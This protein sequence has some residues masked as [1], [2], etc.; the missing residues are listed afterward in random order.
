LLDALDMVAESINGYYN[1][2]KFGVF[3]VSQLR[4]PSGTPDLEISETS[5]LSIARRVTS[6]ASR[7]IPVWRVN[8]SYRKNWT[9]QNNAELSGASAVDIA[10]T[11]QEYRTVQWE[12]A[13][14]KHLYPLAP[15]LNVVTLID[16]EA[17]AQAEAD[18]LGTLHGVQREMYQ[19]SVPLDDDTINVDL[20]NVV[21]LTHS[22]YGLSGGKLFA[23]L[24][25]QIDAK[26]ETVSMTLWG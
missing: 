16:T 9:L 15:E 18:R 11:A 12:D 24:G 8:L 21:Q 13:T 3:Y 17:A 7:G 14:V 4:A 6:D 22:A 1:A 19:I 26:T 2:T 20:N 5:V 10:F 23:V 25:Y